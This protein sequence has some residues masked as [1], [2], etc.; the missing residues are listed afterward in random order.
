MSEP[1]VTPQLALVKS[2][3]AVVCSNGANPEKGMGSP[4]GNSVVYKSAHLTSALLEGARLVEG[5]RNVHN[6]E[7]VDKYPHP[8]A[9]LEFFYFVTQRCKVGNIWEFPIMETHRV[10]TSVDDPK[11]DRV[12]FSDE[13]EQLCGVI[14]HRGRTGNRFQGCNPRRRV[15]NELRWLW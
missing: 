9:N 8:F 11:Q 6:G 10:F 1:I 3:P 12:I 14:T 15:R 13:P 7:Q 4:F 2:L 5:V